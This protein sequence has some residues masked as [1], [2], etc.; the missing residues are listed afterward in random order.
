MS[1]R[2]MFKQVKDD[3]PGYY[4]KGK[5]D[6][7]SST[8]KLVERDIPKAL[9]SMTGIGPSY[10]IQGSTGKGNTSPA[11]WVAILDSRITVTAQDGYYVVYL[12]SI[13]LK[14]VFA[15][16][17]FGITTFKE[18]FGGGKVQREKLREAAEDVGESIGITGN[19][20]TGSIDLGAGA[21]LSKNML[22]RG[23]EESV[24]VS[25]EYDLSNLPDDETIGSDLGQLLEWYEQL[26]INRGEYAHEE[27]AVEKAE[28]SDPDI[29]LYEI[30]FQPR[31]LNPK[32]KKS[33]SK[34]KGSTF[35]RKSKSAKK[36][37]DAGEKLV[38]QYEIKR[39]E[40]EGRP[41]LE[42][43]W[44]A[45]QGEKPGYDILSFNADGS[46]RW[47]EV[48]TTSGKKLSVVHLTEH[49]R[50]VASTAPKGKYWIY[51]VTDV[52]KPKP[53]VEC[54]QDPYRTLTWEEGENP[55]PST[56][57]LTLG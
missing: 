18:K 12:F 31:N 15:C 39:L 19:F 14:R 46:E 45:D 33:Q 1:L 5:T 48:K 13:E 55:R 38:E 41:D 3:Y 57:D 53:K 26:R 29:L 42:V 37:G 27:I 25:V 30:P 34:N 49:E 23:Y 4:R 6:S 50:E 36:I 20:K 54:I 47:I 8:Y 9:E 16:L 52:F 44:L 11:P 17:A 22:H 24:I 51:I 40:K 28:I 32:K 2:E 21:D 7:N 56:W 10:N 43:Q 35:P